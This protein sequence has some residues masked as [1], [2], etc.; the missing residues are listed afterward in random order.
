MLLRSNS[1]ALLMAAGLSFPLTVLATPSKETCPVRSNDRIVQVAIFDGDPAELA[2]LGPDDEERPNVYTVG[3]IYDQ[4][5]YVTIRCHY[6]G[7]AALDI[8]LKRRV[9]QCIY[10]Q[11]KS[12]VNFACK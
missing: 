12:N 3:G 8:P 6:V 11:H 10:A 2:F 5:R 4:G 9:Q 7:G 1:S